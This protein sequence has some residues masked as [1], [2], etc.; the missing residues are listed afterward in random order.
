MTFDKRR[1]LTEDDLWEGVQYITWKKCLRLLTLTVT[2]QLTPNRKFY[3]LSLT[4]NRIPHDGRNVRGIMHVHVCRKDSFWQR[5]LN[6][7]GVGGGIVFRW[8][9]PA[10]AYT[11]LWKTTFNVRRPSMEDN[12]WWKTTF[13]GRR[14]LMEDDLWRNTSFDGRRHLMEDDLWWK[15]TFDGSQLLMEGIWP[16]KY[17]L[18]P[19]MRT[20]SKT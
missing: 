2:A 14:P 15:T 1:P 5:R 4:G 7:S 11:T 10:W 20:T 16:Q 18:T 6:N 13:D 9:Y 8:V 3:Q 17:K 12:L 19:I